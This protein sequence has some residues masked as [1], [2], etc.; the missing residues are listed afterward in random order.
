MKR[1]LVATD[2]SPSATEAARFGIELAKEHDSELVFAHVVRALD[3]VPSTVFQIGGVFEHEPGEHDVEL[4]DDAATLASEQ[5][6]VSTTALLRGETVEELVAYAAAREVDLIVVGTRGHGAVT[7][8]LLGSV[9]QGLLRE[10]RCPVAIVRAAAD[11]R[12]PVAVEP[13]AA[14]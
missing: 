12:E 1:I 5:G 7:G 8:A 14:P 9:S 6:V 4:L 10:A 13:A 3:V 11:A 2:G